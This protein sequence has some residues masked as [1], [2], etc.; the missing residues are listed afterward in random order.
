MSQMTTLVNDGVKD[1][2]AIANWPRRTRGWLQG[3]AKK[4]TV[5]GQKSRLD[6]VFG[7]NEHGCWAAPDSLHAP[8]IPSLYLVGVKQLQIGQ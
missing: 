5:V 3:S 8:Q 1:R 4:K 6:I 2:I 7:G